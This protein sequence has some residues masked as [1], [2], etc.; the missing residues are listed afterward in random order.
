MRARQRKEPQRVYSV[1][2]RLQ[3]LEEVTDLVAEKAASCE[4]DDENE[5]WTKLLIRLRGIVGRLRIY[6]RKHYG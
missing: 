5:K 3:D 1:T 2:F 4:K 6:D